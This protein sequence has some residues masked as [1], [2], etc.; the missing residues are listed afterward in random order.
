M[1]PPSQLSFETIPE[2][3]ASSEL[4]QSKAWQEMIEVGGRICQSLG[5][6]RSTGQIFGLLYLS[7]EPLS[8]NRMSSML[9]ISK[10][11]ASVGT[12]QLVLWG[13]FAKSG[14]LAIGATTTR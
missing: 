12:R 7:V 13:R 4:A 8:L 3:Q 2:V 10:G 11:S 6:P 14:F 5:L 9:G 1:L